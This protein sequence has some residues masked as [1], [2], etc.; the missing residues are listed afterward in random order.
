MNAKTET[1]DAAYLAFQNALTE[2]PEMLAEKQAKFEKAFGKDSKS[3]T[4]KQWCNLVR[5]YGME[6]VCLHEKLSEG[7]VKL[8]CM[9]LT[10]R[11]KFN[12]RAIK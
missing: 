9:S 1:H 11:L 2:S 5:V 8:N 7:D 10:E 3:R 4:R 6:T 12:S